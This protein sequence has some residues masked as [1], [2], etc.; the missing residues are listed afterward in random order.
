L[1]HAFPAV[2]SDQINSSFAVVSSGASERLPVPSL[3][4]IRTIA[5]R[6]TLT[7]VSED[8]DLLGNETEPEIIAEA[9]HLVGSIQEALGS[10]GVNDA[11][12][13]N[14]Y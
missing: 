3:C 8:A 7:L 2:A 11:G 13:L 12:P 5:S 1:N 10:A 4:P 14:S 6:W 9:T